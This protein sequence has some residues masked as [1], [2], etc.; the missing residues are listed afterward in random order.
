MHNDTDPFELALTPELILR[1]YEFGVFPMAESAASSELFWVDPEVRGILPLDGLHVSRSLKKTIQSGKFQW[2]V[3]RAF[4]DVMAACAKP[5][6]GRAETW[7]NADIL[8]LYARLH[9]SGHAHSVEVWAD[10]EL[11]GGLYGLAIGGAFFGESMF[12]TRTDASKVALVHLVSRLNAGGFGL[13]DMQF[14]T[15]HLKSLGGIE[16]PRAEYRQRLAAALELQPEFSPP[17]QGSR[18]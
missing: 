2:T 8:H 14:L 15:D 5:A 7:I 17:E 10:G 11:A 3:D 9:Q 4:E 12:H 16:I 6:A 18:T 1:A 13:L